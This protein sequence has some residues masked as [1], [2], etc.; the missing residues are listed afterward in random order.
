MS[1][2]IIIK[3]YVDFLM[4]WCCILILAVMTVLVTFQVVTRYI[5]N[6][7]SAISEATAQYLFVWMVMF[8]SAYVFGLREHLSITVIKDKLAPL[9]NMIVEIIS[10]ILLFIFAL[11]VC[12]YGGF[13]G[14]M[15]QM[16]TMDASLKIPMGLI[17][18]A[19]PVCGAAMLFY[20]VYNIALAVQEYHSNDRLLGDSSSSTM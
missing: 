17:Y 2:L 18:I 12:V 15:K 8:G 14:A 3:K 19:I 1:A 20:A 5:F 10:N 6:S 11:S 9:P 4:Q 13:Q 16:G 7:P